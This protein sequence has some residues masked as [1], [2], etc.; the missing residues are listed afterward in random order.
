MKKCAVCKE[1][2]ERGQTW[3]MRDEE[4]VHWK[5]AHNVSTKSRA[6]VPQQAQ[7]KRKKE[8]WPCPVCGAKNNA[9]RTTCKRGC[10]DGIRPW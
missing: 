6:S 7:R 3:S 2:I 8:K 9:S 5:C 10:P 4:P 1:T